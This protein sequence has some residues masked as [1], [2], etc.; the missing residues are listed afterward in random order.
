MHRRD[1]LRSMLL[2]GGALAAPKVLHATSGSPASPRP[3]L[4]LL[5][6]AGGNDGMNTLIPYRDPRYY[7]LRPTLALRPE[8]TLQLNNEV[9]L[10][11]ALRPL[12][13]AWEAG[14]WAWVE[15]VGY[16]K[17]NRSHFR[18][19]DIWHRGSKELTGGWLSRSYATNSFFEEGGT[20]AVSLAGSTLPF[21]GESGL[22]F[23]R[24]EGQF[25]RDVEQLADWELHSGESPVAAGQLF[26][27]LREEMI[28][29]SRDVQSAPL[30]STAVSLEGT[31][32]FN[33]QIQA[34]FKL[35]TH[36]TLHVPVI[37]LSLGG[38]DTHRQ[39]G[40]RHQNLL[41][42]MARGLSSLRRSLL[43]AERWN[44]CLIMSYSEFGRRPKENGSR[45]TDHG[46][47]APHFFLGGR[48]RGGLYGQRPLIDESVLAGADLNHRVDFRHLYSTV[49][50]NWF[51]LSE[52]PFAAYA[53]ID[54]LG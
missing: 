4:I 36:P 34:A 50:T 51:R 7:E 40:H 26:Q 12:L 39:Q 52:N 21:E 27:R 48:V 1:F 8:T 38:F 9:A 45:G 18:S 32:S 5:Q 43:R 29:F 22:R 53:P 35:I 25:E 54:C 23:V 42:E 49:L 10:H 11:P 3:T 16:E 41:R 6:L 14:D 30:S 31:G 20:H 2:S 24:F 33:R 37:K 46:T 47:A 44:D 19:S 17:P 15:G 13:S 28:L